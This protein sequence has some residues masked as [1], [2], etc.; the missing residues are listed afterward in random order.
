MEENNDC[1]EQC[2]KT[3]NFS[4]IRQVELACYS[5]SVMLVLMCDKYTKFKQ[6]IHRN[7]QQLDC[8]WRNTLP[9]NEAKLEPWHP[10]HYVCIK[11][12][13]IYLCQIIMMLNY[14][15]WK[16]EANTYVASDEGTSADVQSAKGNI[17][18]S[19]DTDTIHLGVLMLLGSNLQEF[20]YFLRNCKE[21]VDEN[22]VPKPQIHL[23]QVLERVRLQMLIY[24]K[25]Y[26]LVGASNSIA[27][28]F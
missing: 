10:E 20:S 27:Y 12:D 22:A 19:C 26:L 5:L 9:T 14:A 15:R 1:A 28:L 7:L 23:Y 11:S 25:Y 16:P 21:W 3:S 4:E 24:R 2:T 18:T 13:L 6:A 17:V 8:E